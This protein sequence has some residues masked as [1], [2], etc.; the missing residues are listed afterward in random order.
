MTQNKWLQLKNLLVFIDSYIAE[1][2]FHIFNS[3]GILRAEDGVV[4][5]RQQC[6]YRKL[7]CIYNKT[8][9]VAWQFVALPSL[10]LLPDALNV[11]NIHTTGYA[12][13]PNP[14][15]AI[16]GGNDEDN[17]VAVVEGDRG[18]GQTMQLF[19]RAKLNCHS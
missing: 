5:N 16:V 19:K 1:L 12:Y 18:K 9:S 15:L 13:F 3:S 6:D 14:S 11:L 10:P 8:R 4:C 2:H 7:D 17:F